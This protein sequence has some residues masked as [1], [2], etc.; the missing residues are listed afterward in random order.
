MSF[1]KFWQSQQREVEDD[2]AGPQV[3]SAG[4]FD[5]LIAESSVPMVVDF[6]A[7]W[8]G[9]CHMLAPSVHK[10]AHEYA[11]RA[12][13]AKVDADAYPEL[14][15]RYGIMGIPTLLYF[16]DGKLADRV[17]GVNPYNTLKSKLDRLTQA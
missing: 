13:V 16:R 14:L 17:I 15:E 5:R 1:L 3:V 11:G 2:G 10:L 4:E 12:V 8:C 6:W 7:E 9:P